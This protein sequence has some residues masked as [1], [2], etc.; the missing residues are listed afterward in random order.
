M[1][2]ATTTT[3]ISTEALYL[4]MAQ[5]ALS[6]AGPEGVL[7]AQLVPAIQMLWDQVTATPAA[8]VTLVQLKAIVD[9]GTAA[10]AQA[11]ADLAAQGT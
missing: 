7:A 4:A 9:G 5:A 3:P 1:T 10:L 11:N 2:D 6:L 8:N